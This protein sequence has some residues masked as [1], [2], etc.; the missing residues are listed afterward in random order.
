MAWIYWSG[1][2]VVLNSVGACVRCVSSLHEEQGL[3]P[4]SGG[5]RLDLLQDARIPS[6]IRA[7]AVASHHH[8]ASPQKG[9]GQGAGSGVAEA[10]R[11][12]V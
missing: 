11:T 5:G 10:R 4:G 1:T 2:A 7:P 3:H 8:R 12:D 9:S 6:C